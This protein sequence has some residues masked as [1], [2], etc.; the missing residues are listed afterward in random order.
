MIGGKTRD[1]YY[2]RILVPRNLEPFHTMISMIKKF[3]WHLTHMITLRQRWRF[4]QAVKDMIKTL[5]ATMETLEL[6]S[7]THNDL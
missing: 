1:N 2:R 3:P 6:K 4:Y 5:A 7:E